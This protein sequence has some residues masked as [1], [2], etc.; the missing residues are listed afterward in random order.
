[1]LAIWIFI[2]NGVLSQKCPCKNETL[3]ENIKTQYDKEL[4]GFR[5]QNI[6]LPYYNWTYITTMAWADNDPD[7][8][9]TAHSHG[10]RLITSLNNI[11]IPFTNSSEERLNWIK[12]EFAIVK[13]QFFDGLTFDYESPMTLNSVQSQQYTQLINETTIYFHENMPGSQ[14]YKSSL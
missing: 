2:I 4:F 14:V 8:L 5:A 10:V 12:Q 1:M 6:S 9:C 7:V 13:G 3:C 11:A